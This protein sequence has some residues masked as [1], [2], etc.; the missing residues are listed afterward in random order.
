[1]PNS[2]AAIVKVVLIVFIVFAMPS[3]AFAAWN[4]VTAPLRSVIQ[5]ST[6]AETG[7]GA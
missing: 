5:N 4:D 3:T 7:V 6:I 1:M 2:I